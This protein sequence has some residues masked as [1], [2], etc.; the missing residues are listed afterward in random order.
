MEW[1]FLLIAYL[2]VISIVIGLALLIAGFA[3]RK[4]KEQLSN[5]LFIA[6]GFCVGICLLIYIALFFV[7]ALGIGPVPN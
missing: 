4:T 5:E 1:L 6:G 3:L 2:P 7:G